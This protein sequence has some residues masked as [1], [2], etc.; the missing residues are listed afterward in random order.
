MD[1]Y[2]DKSLME[3]GNCKWEFKEVT[4][5]KKNEYNEGDVVLIT[6]WIS[7]ISIKKHYFKRE[8]PK[9]RTKHQGT[10]RWY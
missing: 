7:K 4:P 3:N 6:N 1:N 2:N 8:K 10:D 5:R 9:K